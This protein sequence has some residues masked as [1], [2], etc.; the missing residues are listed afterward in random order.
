MVSKQCVACGGY[1]VG[2]LN[3]DY[4]CPACAQAGAAAP[5]RPLASLSGLDPGPDAGS[6]PAGPLRAHAIG[7]R[8]A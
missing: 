6:P 2:E 4:I 7:G 3:G 5:M 8:A 1:F